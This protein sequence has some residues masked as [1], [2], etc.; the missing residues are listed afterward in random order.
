MRAN[1]LL[2]RNA[3]WG[4][5]CS[6]R[7]GAHALPRGRGRVRRGTVPLRGWRRRRTLRSLPPLLTIL[8]AA[9]AWA[10][11]DLAA[12]HTAAAGQVTAFSDRSANQ[13]SARGDGVHGFVFHR[14][15]RRDLFVI[16]G[17]GNCGFGFACGVNDPGYGYRYYGDGGD[18]GNAV[19]GSGGYSGGSNSGGYSGGGYSGGGYVPD[20]VGAEIS[21]SSLF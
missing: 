2:W 5:P 3:L 16:Y 7:S 12:P 1:R 6:V 20:P 8:L 13:R 15:V 19:S 10:Q 18:G 11:A 14:G 17:Y 4:T 9:P 21:A